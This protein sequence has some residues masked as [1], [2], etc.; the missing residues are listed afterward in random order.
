[1]VPLLFPAKAY[2][3]AQHEA[4]Q[5]V[6]AQ[7]SP[8]KTVQAG[9]KHQRQGVAGHA[10]QTTPDE[11]IGKRHRLKM[12]VG[13]TKVGNRAGQT[14][15][16]LHKKRLSKNLRHIFSLALYKRSMARLSAK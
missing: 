8:G 9:F 7:G 15:Y 1:M 10:T 11:N 3:D 13:L 12:C 16:I 4:A 2:H 5:H 6:G 14:A